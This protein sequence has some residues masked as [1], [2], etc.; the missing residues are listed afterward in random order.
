MVNTAKR[1]WCSRRAGIQRFA[2]CEMQARVS[3]SVAVAVVAVGLRNK[4]CVVG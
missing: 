2:Q 4:I 1:F 3:C